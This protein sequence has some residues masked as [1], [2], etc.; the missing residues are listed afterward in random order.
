MFWRTETRYLIVFTSESETQRFGK[1]IVAA[2]F[3]RSWLSIFF[4]LRPFRT[5]EGNFRTEVERPDLVAPPETI[6]NRF[7]DTPFETF[8]VSD[9]RVD[10][11]LPDFGL[12][13]GLLV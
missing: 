9:I 12:D 8:S 6:R 2:V 10:P 7:P 5:F 13:L 3:V 1:K 11:A 4:T